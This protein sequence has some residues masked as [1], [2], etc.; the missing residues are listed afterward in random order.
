MDTSVAPLGPWRID[1][2]SLSFELGTERVEVTSVLDVVPTGA[3]H[4]PLVLDGAGLTTLAVEV[5]DVALTDEQY[6]LAD[7]SLTLTLSPGPHTVTTRVAV[8]PAPPHS[9]GIVRGPSLLFTDCEPQGFRRITWFLDRPSNRATFDVTMVAD[10]A[11]YPTMLSN[12]HEVD[13][14]ELADG[15]HWVRFDDP[16]TKPSYLFSMV[17][18]EL[19]L[20]SR[21]RTSASG[22][23]MQIAVAASLD[24]VEGA[25]FALGVL[26]SAMAFD[27]ANGGI[28]HDLDGLTLVA[29]PGY[30]DATE[31]HGLMFFEP[32]LLVVDRAGFVDDDLLLI[33]A[34]VAHEYG[35]HVRGNRVTVSSWGQL[36]LKEGLTVLQGQNDFRRHWLGD[37][38]RVLDVLDLRRLQFPE[39]VTIGAPVLRGEVSDPA[40][41][42]NRTTYLKGAEI[43]GMLRTLLGADTWR[44][45]FDE[46]LAR[47]DLGSVG[48]AE[49]LAVVRDVVPNRAG[50]IDG[51]ARW[52]T[53]AGRPALHIAPSQ[54]SIVVRRTDA[55]TDDPPVQMPVV[56]GF[57]GVDGKPVKVSLDG[58]GAAAEH[59]VLLT[60]RERTLTVN[61]NR[62]WVMS[63]LRRYS[64]PVDLSVEMPAESLA[65]LVQHDTDPFAR[66]WASQELMTRIVD[67]VRADREAS[68]ET[69]LDVL[70]AALRP[71]MATASDPILLANMLAVP[72]E[73]MLGDREPQI[74]VDGVANGLD[75]LRY[76]LGLRLH[77][78]VL[79]AMD[80]F[81]DDDPAGEKATDIAIRWL[82]EPALA[83]LLATGS[84]DA[85]EMALAQLGSLNPTRAVRALTQLAHYDEVPLDD[86][87]A[88]TYENWQHSP[89]LVDRWLRAQSGSRRSDTVERVKALAA[90]PLYDRS[91]R[92]RVMSVWFPFATRNRSVFHTASGE[93][94]RAFVD[95]LGV[96]M[97][98][99]AGLAVRL[100]GDLLQFQRFDPARRALL[101]AELAR[102]AEMDGMPDFAVSIV[103][104]L[105]A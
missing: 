19:A 79:A 87:L 13:R 34:N 94:Y 77:D 96:L 15:R 1:H 68:A 38:A 43:F 104:S 39:E 14:G 32:S 5:D 100:V 60:G 61:A 26:A 65:V 53:T 23:E 102:L 37:A 44:T 41:L 33:A 35:H 97:P 69:T 49:F 64:A 63:P 59:T 90:G 93:G 22:R 58:G 91:D 8:R 89:K 11:Q 84:D 70:A 48:V 101:R 3:D 24:T 95:E 80:R 40:A 83:L 82:V 55:L 30:S 28:E 6:E 2:V 72:D 12:G 50:A 92:A 75:A 66:W 18:G 9:K 54:E 57:V 73:F 21:E 20:W 17:A 29:V 36:T 42:Y 7:R 51:V 16:V 98:T 81:A 85:A 31:Y 25:D 86:L 71:V 74:D 99:N 105:L 10:P 4:G 46:F 103:R 56:L 88:T 52:F 62:P 76:Q 47:H 78:D 45:V 67:D 27:E